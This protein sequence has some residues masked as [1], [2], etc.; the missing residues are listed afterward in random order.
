MRLPDRPTD[1][2]TERPLTFFFVS[3]FCLQLCL[4]GLGLPAGRLQQEALWFGG[5]GESSSLP[6]VLAALS[7]PVCGCE[8]GG[9]GRGREEEEVMVGWG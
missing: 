1:R 2:P 4:G 9:E 8:Q 3:F 6:A 5:A 7:P